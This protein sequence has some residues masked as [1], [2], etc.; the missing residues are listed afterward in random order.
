[1]ALSK[2]NYI[3][4]LHTHNANTPNLLQLKAHQMAPCSFTQL[5]V[6]TGMHPVSYIIISSNQMPYS[7]VLVKCIESN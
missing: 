4:I 5:V 3:R 6:Y 7:Q 2:N 1:M